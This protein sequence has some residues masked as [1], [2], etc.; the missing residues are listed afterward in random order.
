MTPEDMLAL[1]PFARTIGIELV[2]ATKKKVVGRLAWADDRTTAAGV[3]HGGAIMSLGDS[4]G[5]VC[6]FLNLPEG[7]GT[8]TVSSNTVF[9][10]AV[11]EGTIT[12]TAK[13]MHVGRTTIAVRTELRDDDD[14]L[15]AQMTQTQAVLGK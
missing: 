11:R 2:S 6:A 8:S 13:P 3:L 12:A 5:A 4:T 15:V 10:G 7:A 14:R 9:M 1:M